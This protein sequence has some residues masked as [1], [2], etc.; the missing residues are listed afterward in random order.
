MFVS[1]GNVRAG[2]LGVDGHAQLPDGR[3][4]LG[5]HLGLCRMLSLADDG[6]LPKLG[7]VWGGCSRGSFL[8]PF[9]GEFLVDDIG[10]M[11]EATVVL[12][13]SDDAP[14]N[15]GDR[16]CPDG[17]GELLDGFVGVGRRLD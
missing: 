7:H 5:T 13:L 1:R 17:D 15:E 6:N 11:G 16:E 14:V 9:P 2:K 10:G 8:V 3:L 4:N 12:F